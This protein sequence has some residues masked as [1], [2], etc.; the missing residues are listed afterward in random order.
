MAA[1]QTVAVE[2]SEAT[3][4]TFEVVAAK[5]GKRI[6]VTGYHLGAAGTNTVKFSGT[7][8]LT[9]PIPTVAG[10][11][12][13]ATGSPDNVL[14]KVETSVA[15]SVTLSAANSVCGYINYVILDER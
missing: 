6:A 9:G 2:F 8:D 15:L 7:A 13:V 5:T 4:A 14:F 12:L 11:Q 10:S 3:A 1:F